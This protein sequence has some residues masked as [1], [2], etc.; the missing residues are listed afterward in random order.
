MLSCWPMQRSAWAHHQPSTVCGPSL[1]HQRHG[2]LLPRSS[3]MRSADNASAASKSISTLKHLRA[4]LQ[5]DTHLVMINE[6]N[7]FEAAS[8]AC[9]AQAMTLEPGVEKAN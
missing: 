2:P 4:I 6:P 8:E 3:S 9:Y 5:L 1:S 7:T